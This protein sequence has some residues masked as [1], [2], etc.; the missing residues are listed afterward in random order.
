MDSG[1]PPRLSLPILF[2]IDKFFNWMTFWPNY[3]WVGLSHP[4]RVTDLIAVAAAALAGFAD[5]ELSARYRIRTGQKIGSAALADPAVGLLITAAIL[6]VLREAAREIC[7]RLMDAVDP[8][9]THQAENA[10]RATW[11]PGCR[12]GT[13]PLDRPPD[14][15]RV[16]D[17]S[18][19][20]HHRRAGARGHG[21][22]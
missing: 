8:A 18:R 1:R 16:R 7:R 15:R 2:G 4:H 13:A 12:A 6:A 21:Q 20:G 14:P 22:R 10:L 11:R 19:P 3:L 9:L 17:R 5:N